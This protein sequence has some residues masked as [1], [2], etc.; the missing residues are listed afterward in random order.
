MGEIRMY[1]RKERGVGGGGDKNTRRFKKS[2]I[3]IR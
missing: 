3:C 1:V 2:A